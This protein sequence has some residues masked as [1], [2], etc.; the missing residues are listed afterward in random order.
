M[1]KG[2]FRNVRKQEENVH[3]FFKDPSGFPDPKIQNRQRTLDMY[4]DK[5]EQ[6]RILVTLTGHPVSELDQN[7][8]SYLNNSPKL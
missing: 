1:L 4:T 7:G 3:V 2:S 6:A 5:T 8:A